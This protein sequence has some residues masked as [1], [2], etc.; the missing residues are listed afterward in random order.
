MDV[1][2]IVPFQHIKMEYQK[3]ANLLENASNQILVMILNL[4]LLW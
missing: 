3:I 2:A 1:N 4:K